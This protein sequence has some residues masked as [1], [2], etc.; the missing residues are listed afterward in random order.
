M[1]DDL[2]LLLVDF[3]NHSGLKINFIKNKMVPLNL[4]DQEASQYANIICRKI[5][6][7]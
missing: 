3:E 6:S 1:V 7:L 5:I 4:T 2:K